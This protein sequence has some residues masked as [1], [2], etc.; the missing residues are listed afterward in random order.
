MYMYIYIYIYIN[1]F[2]PAWIILRVFHNNLDLQLG[3][4]YLLRNVYFIFLSDNIFSITSIN[5]F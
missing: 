4:C 1:I 3:I 5:Y 2:I